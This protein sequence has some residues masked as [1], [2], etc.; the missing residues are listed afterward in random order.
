MYLFRS[1][2]FLEHGVG[3]KMWKRGPES[4]VLR[5]ICSRTWNDGVNVTGEE[6]GEMEEGK[7]GEG[8]SERR[9][10]KEEE[11]EEKEEMK[12]KEEEEEEEEKEKGSGGEGQD[13][14][15]RFLGFY[16]LIS[17]SIMSQIHLRR[18]QCCCIFL[19]YA[20][21]DQASSVPIDHEACGQ[22]LP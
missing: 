1:E 9:R 16:A 11:K 20:I 8:G 14:W 4:Q 22:C 17:P 3:L 7:R 12:E 18:P 19:P 2:K 15:E 6:Q 5:V 13:N 21:N 10:K